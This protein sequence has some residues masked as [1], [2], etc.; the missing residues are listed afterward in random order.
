MKSHWETGV[1]MDSLEPVSFSGTDFGR[2]HY[3]YSLSL[4]R[5]N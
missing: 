1:E 5:Q 4:P 3:C 2:C